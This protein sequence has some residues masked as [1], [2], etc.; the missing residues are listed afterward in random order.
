[1][2]SHRSLLNIIGNAKEVF[3]E[4]C[5]V[6]PQIRI[7]AF[8]EEKKTVV[9]ITDNGGGI[10]GDIIDRIFE[11]YFTT[12]K[13]ENGTGIGLWMSKTIIE[14]NMDGKLSVSNVEGG[15]RFRIEV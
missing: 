5:T 4:R 15:A 8:R 1:M 14:K 7:E 2:S 10:P 3:R 11:P 13:R 12:R 9:T 6:E